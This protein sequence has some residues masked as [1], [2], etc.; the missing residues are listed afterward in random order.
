MTFTFPEELAAQFV[1]KVSPRNRSKYL[2]EA[3]TEKL[4]ERDRKLIRACQAA[5]DDPEVRAIEKEF[6]AIAEDTAEPWTGAPA[7][8]RVVGAARSRARRRN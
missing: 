2:A 8:R 4:S 6:D 5:N 3:L 7:R 1:R